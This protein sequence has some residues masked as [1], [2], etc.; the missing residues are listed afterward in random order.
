VDAY[1][2]AENTALIVTAPGVLSN[3]HGDNLLAILAKSP[4]SGSLTL[5]QDGSFYYDPLPG[6][7]G[8]D[9]FV[10]QATD[11]FGKS[12]PATVTI[13]IGQSDSQVGRNGDETAIM[14]DNQRPLDSIYLPMIMR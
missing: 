3:D 5:N 7:L 11:L 8:T 1:N 12:T 14:F 13:I 6:E 2:T 4:I 9:S 10:Y